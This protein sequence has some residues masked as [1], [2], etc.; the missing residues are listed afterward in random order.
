MQKLKKQG[1]YIIGVECEDAVLKN[2]IKVPVCDY[3][4]INIS[5]K[6]SVAGENANKNKGTRDVAFVFGNEVDGIPKEIMSLCDVI[7]DIK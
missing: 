4:K 1:F 3:K 5:A 2:K 6:K 7:A